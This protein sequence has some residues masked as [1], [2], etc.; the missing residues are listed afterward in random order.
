M[1]VEVVDMND[2]A[3]VFE[4]IEYIFTVVEGV[5]SRPFPLGRVKATD[6]DSGHNGIIEYVIQGNSNRGE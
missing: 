3:P 4:Q 1:S 6:L 5:F 2:H